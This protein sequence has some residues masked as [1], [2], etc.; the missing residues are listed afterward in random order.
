MNDAIILDVIQLFLLRYRDERMLTL[1]RLNDVMCVCCLDEYLEYVDG[2][3]LGGV[4]REDVDSRLEIYSA[5]AKKGL[6]PDLSI[7]K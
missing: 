6:A 1:E 2:L 4:G 5:T 3:L 7:H